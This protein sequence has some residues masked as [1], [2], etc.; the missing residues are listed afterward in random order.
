MAQSLL[1]SEEQKSY[2]IATFSKKSEGEE[3][4]CATSYTLITKWCNQLHS[5]QSESE[6]HNGFR[7]EKGQE[8]PREELTV[9]LPEP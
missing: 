8:Q 4:E 6:A 2:S 9:T 7:G 1:S 5:Y 3:N